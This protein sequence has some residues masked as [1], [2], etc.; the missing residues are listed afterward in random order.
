M[1]YRFF[2]EL[3]PSVN[4]TPGIPALVSSVSFSLSR[5]L[6][7]VMTGIALKGAWRRDLDGDG[8]SALVLNIP[9]ERDEARPVF[10]RV[11]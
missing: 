1:Q 5:A 4:T 6:K 8:G 7:Q 11:Y 3:L 10:R 9:V 2:K